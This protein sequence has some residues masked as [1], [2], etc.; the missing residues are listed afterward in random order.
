MYY[1]PNPPNTNGIFFNEKPD[2]S[3]F[4]KVIGL[5][6][7]LPITFCTDL[8]CNKL[9]KVRYLCVLGG[10]IYF[11]TLYIKSQEKS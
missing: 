3:R 8:A 9:S 6:N 1:N 11:Y 7:L 10:R 5:Q 2:F 4:L